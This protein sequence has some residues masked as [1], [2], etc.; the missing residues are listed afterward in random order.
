M[1]YDEAIEW[2]LS[3]ADFE[4]SG[5]FQERPDVAPMLALLER[6]GN[7]HLGRPTVHIAGS[8]GKGSVATMVASILS[9]GSFYPGLYTSPHLQSYRERIQVDGVPIL[10]EDFAMLVEHPLKPAAEA[11]MEAVRDRNLVT[12]DLLTALSFLHFREFGAET[13]VV[14]VGLGGRVDS[15]NV[16][17]KKEVAVITPISFEHT[18]ILGDRIDQIAS[19]KTAI[20]TRRCTVVMAPQP[21]EEAASVVN[22]RCSEV[23]PPLY[24]PHLIDVRRDYGWR[25][26][27]NDMRTQTVQIESAGSSIN[28]TIPLLGAHQIENAATAVACIDAMNARTLD[29][30]GSEFISE[31]LASVRWP[32]RIEVLREDPLVIA[33]GAHNRD[34]AR[35]LAE[36]LVEYFVAD[37]ALFVIGCGSDKDIDGLAE[38]LAPLAS[39]VLSVRS[40]HPRA[41]DPQ[42]IVEAF[43]R[44]NVD[45]EIVDKV[46]DA[47][48]RAIA[49]A[50]ARALICVAGSLFVAAEARAHVLGLGT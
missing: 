19:E 41:M 1:T 42:R 29:S 37:R 12:F 10:K 23:E 3:F 25:K 7:P 5:R 45:G 26:V 24:G 31:G 39:R 15:T 35:R 47:V 18:D 2:L 40:E 13:W 28:A 32:C 17:P 20:I 38:E 46:P 21:H 34:S 27:Q 6:L 14:E 48:D 49:D 4:R 36:T 43:E 11:V 30:Y 44:L 22:S 50:G 8:K 33:D 9:A 16:F